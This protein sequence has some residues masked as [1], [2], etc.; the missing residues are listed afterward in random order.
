MFGSSSGFPEET[1]RKVPHFG[2]RALIGRARRSLGRRRRRAGGGGR[3]EVTRRSPPSP[4][5][6]RVVSRPSDDPASPP[7]ISRS[8]EPAFTKSM[9]NKRRSHDWLTPKGGLSASPTAALPSYSRG[10]WGGGIRR[11][12]PAG[13]KWKKVRESI[14]TGAVNHSGR[15]SPTRSRTPHPRSSQFIKKNYYDGNLISGRFSPA[16]K[17]AAERG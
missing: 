5:E 7:G 11:T 15:G 4:E 14:T 13:D 17:S 10:A 1:D 6:P 3:T 16:G 9:T 2:R 8:T 12:A